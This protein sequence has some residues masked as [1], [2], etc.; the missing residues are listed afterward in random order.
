MKQKMV[1]G[2]EIES[3]TPDELRGIIA[4]AFSGVGGAPEIVQARKDGT[5]DANGNLTLAVYTIPPGQEYVH[6]RMIV[7][8]ASATPASP[9]T[10][11][12][13][14]LLV[15]RNDIPVDFV[16]LVPGATGLPAISTDSESQAPVFR[17]GDT[18]SVQL[19]SGPATTNIVVSIRGIG[20]GLGDE[21]Q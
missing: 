20:Y 10:G 5:T 18:L 6:T 12:G 3:V 7:W 4:E 21:R 1:P 8:A 11:A 16:S 17:Q 15:L 13:A 9:W 14:Y 19:V 2:A